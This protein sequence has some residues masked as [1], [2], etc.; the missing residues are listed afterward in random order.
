[1]KSSV[2]TEFWR[3][4]E[5]LPPDIKARARRAFALWQRNPRHPSFCFRKAG[6]VWTVRI[7]RGFRAL[8]LLRGDTFYWFWVG[9]HDDYEKLLGNPRA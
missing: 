6:E 4:F 8:A 9:P 3:S 2:T 5:T 7:A 1:M